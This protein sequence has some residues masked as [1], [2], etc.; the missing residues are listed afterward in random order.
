VADS[1]VAITAGTGTNI[2]TRTAPDGNH[3]Q[4]VVLGDESLVAVAEVTDPANIT[5]ALSGGSQGA[6]LNVNPN[7]IQKPTFLAT[8]SSVAT[9]ALTA[10]TAKPVLTLHH[11][12]TA[13]KTVRIRRIVMGAMQ[14]TLLAGSDTV[15]ITRGTAAPTGGGAV[16]PVPAVPGATAAETT[17]TSLP[18]SITAATTV[19]AQI[20][21]ITAATA[22]TGF[23]SFV[24]YDW[25]ESGET[26][27]LTL[28]AGSLDAIVINL[29]SSAAKNYT[30]SVTVIFTEE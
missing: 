30:T 29:L 23:A 24:V 7:A 8:L 10:A 1:S 11:A 5:G 26:I 15:V 20:G 17:V 18:T 27:P 19:L 6:A 12:A 3:R 25:Q 9:G 2:D 21:A 13:T 14:T 4:V 16:T 22:N 28:R